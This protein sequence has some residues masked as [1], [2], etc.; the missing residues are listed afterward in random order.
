[1]NL[2]NLCIS[3]T[4]F[5]IIILTVI[6]VAM[7]GGGE[8]K[9]YL[10][11]HIRADSNEPMAQA[12]KYCVKDAVVDYLT[13]FIA[14]CDTKSKAEKML[15]ERLSDIEQTANAVLKANG[16]CYTAKASVKTEEFPTRKYGDLT[17]NQGFYRALI[18]ELGSGQGDN[19]WCVV[20]PPLCFTGEGDLVYKSKIAE[21][22]KKLRGEMQ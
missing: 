18:I 17:L 12:V 6:G 5:L 19:W 15:N 16:F 7:S 21:I 8:E 10:R 4:L 3:F 2:K 9:E 20:Y 11:I 14:Q 22:I 1:M 13:P